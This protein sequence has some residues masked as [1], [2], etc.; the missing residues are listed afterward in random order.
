MSMALTHD[1]FQPRS[2]THWAPGA[3]LALAVHALLVIALAFSVNWHSSEP[4]GVIA[5]LWTSTPQIAAP[6]PTAT[7]EPTPPP[8]PL[9]TPSKPEPEVRTP[10]PPDRSLADA[11]IA[12]E[13]AAAAS[14][15]RADQARADAARLAVIARRDAE[16][17]QAKRAADAVAEAKSKAKSQA[18]AHVKATQADAQ[19]SKR[20]TEEDAR[21]A[22]ARQAAIRQ[23]NLRK[24]MNAAGTSD[25]ANSTGTAA[26]TSGPSA[27]YAGRIKARIKPNIVLT[28]PVAGDPHATV[29]VR[30]G[31]DGTITGRSLEKSSGDAVYDDAVLRAIDRTGQLPRDTDGRVPPTMLIEFN[32]RE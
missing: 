29:L 4:E 19:A 22:D 5:E 32:A 18:D 27:G 16:R 6:K 7:V 26:R 28:S 20:K 31:P 11:K 24:M 15:A 25:D 30:L 14:A 1:A 9:P 8:M 10:P 3:L 12:T 17:E 23:A 2:P 21:A 13:R